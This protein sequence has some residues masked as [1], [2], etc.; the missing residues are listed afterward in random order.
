MNATVAATRRVDEQS[1]NEIITTEEFAVALK[2]QIKNTHNLATADT[3][4]MSDE[5]A[6][7]IAVRTEAK[8]TEL[9]E[10]SLATNAR[11]DDW[12]H[13]VITECRQRIDE[14]RASSA[15]YLE[16]QDTQLQERSTKRMDEL[17]QLRKDIDAINERET[18]D[19]LKFT[20]LTLRIESE[21]VAE[22]EGYELRISKFES[23][24]ST[25][26]KDV[27]PKKRGAK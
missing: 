7:D 16:Q 13:D 14:R 1:A 5:D 6:T 19:Q 25:G 21:C 9:S 26:A 2:N 15:S 4:K 10:G 24:L 3:P 22:V 23:F 12:A 17:A 20:N 27:S 18:N 11:E 8:L